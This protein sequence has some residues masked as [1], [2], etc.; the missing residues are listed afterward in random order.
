MGSASG[1]SM[2]CQ[3]A[4]AGLRACLVVCLKGTFSKEISK[5]NN[6]SQQVGI[7]KEKFPG[8]QV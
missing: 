2:A 6:M 5:L 4:A 8:R 3:G 7:P 1:C